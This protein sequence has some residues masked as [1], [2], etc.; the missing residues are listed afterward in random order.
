M[1]LLRSEA[2]ERG[3][4]LVTFFIAQYLMSLA[5]RRRYLLDGLPR[6]VTP[7]RSTGMQIPKIATKSPRGSLKL[8]Q[9][10]K[11]DHACVS[12][13]GIRKGLHAE[14]RDGPVLSQRLQL[15]LCNW[16]AKITLSCIAATLA[17]FSST[18]LRADA[19]EEKPCPPSDHQVL[20]ELHTIY[21]VEME[22]T[23]VERSGEPCTEYLTGR[24]KWLTD[25]HGLTLL[26]DDR[27]PIRIEA[28]DLHYLQMKPTI[29]R[30]ML[31][32]TLSRFTKLEHLDLY[33]NPLSGPIPAAVWSQTGLERLDISHATLSG[34]IPAAVGGLTE[35]RVLDLRRN[36]LTGEIPAALGN[37]ANL[38]WIN[39]RLNQLSGE[40]PAA[41]WNHPT[42][43]GLDLSFNA[44]LSGAIPLS[45]MNRP[46]LLRLNIS[47]T[48]ICMPYDDA[49]LERYDPHCGRSDGSSPCRDDY[50]RYCFAV[51]ERAAL[52][53]FFNR[54][55]G[56]EWHR[57]DGWLE[58]SWVDSWSGVKTGSDEY[59]L[60]GWRHRPKAIQK[61][62]VKRLSLSGNNLSGLIPDSLINLP[63]L[64]YL[65]FRGNQ[66]SGPIP[67][68]LGNLTNL[69][70]LR[71]ASNQLSGP[72][73]ASLANLTNLTDLFLGGNQLSGPIPASLANLT[74]LE[75]LSLAS[76]QLSG[77]I[78]ASLGNLNNLKGLGLSHNQLSGEI[79]GEL[80]ALANLEGL[81][82]SNN[83]LSGDI[84]FELEALGNLGRLD[85]SGN[86]L[87]RSI[88]RALGK[89]A[90]LKYLV[91]SNNQFGGAIPTELGNLTQL[92][93][94]RASN[95]QLGGTIPAKL[96]NLAELRR[97]NLEDNRLS[98][99]VPPALGNATEL[100]WLNL[101]GNRL[102]GPVPDALGS[103]TKLAELNLSGNRQLSGPLPLTLT[104]L[105]NL[106]ALDIRGTDLCVPR[107]TAFL[108]WLESISFDGAMC[109]GILLA[110]SPAWVSESDGPRE[111]SV[112]ATLVDGPRDL[113]TI[114]TVAV[115]EDIA[116]EGGDFQ[117][118]QAFDLTI[119][120][121]SSSASETLLFTPIDD[122]H[123]EG[124]E[125]L[126]VRG[127]ATLGGEQH[128]ATATLTL[129]D[130]DVPSTRIL[131]AVS[132]A[133]IL[134]SL[135]PTEVRVTASLAESPRN[136]STVVRVTVTGEAAL[137]AVD[138]EPVAAFD[139]IIPAGYTSVSKLLTVHP[140]DDDLEED[141]ETLL[142]RG[143]ATLEGETREAHATITLVDDDKPSTQV[144]LTLDE[145]VVSESVPLTNVT[146][147]AR[148]DSKPRTEDTAVTITVEGSGVEAAVDFNPAPSFEIT[149]LAGDASGTGLFGVR[150]EN[151]AVDERNE[152]LTVSG[153]TIVPT[154]HVV[155]TELI[156]KD[157]D[158]GKYDG[159]FIR[160][161]AGNT[162]VAD[163]TPAVDASL[164]QPSDVAVAADGT[165][166]VADRGNDR[167]RKIDP[168]GIIT[169]LAGTGDW[170]F[171]GDGG[172][173]S[174]AGLS[175]PEGLA[176]DS[177]G[178]V[179]VADAWNGRVR[180]IDITGTI[181]TLAGT[182]KYSEGGDGGPAIQ[183][184][185]GYPA[186]VAVDASG[187]VFVADSGR[188]QVSK[189]DASGTITTLAGN[190][191]WGYGGDGGP[192]IHAQFNGLSSVAVDIVGNVYVA[193]T[194]NH[195]V[196]KIDASG[197]ISTLAGNGESGDAG[198]GGPAVQAQLNRPRSVAADTV[199]N[200]FVTDA[201]NRRVR[202][203]DTAGVLTTVAGTGDWGY[204]GDGRP[205]LE[206]TLSE[207]SGVAID[208]FGNLF[209]AD[210]W[211]NRIRKID[212]LGTISTIAG[213]GDWKDSEDVLDASSV[214]FRY[215]RGAALDVSGNLL[216]SDDDRVWKL[217]PA[218]TL[219]VFAGMRN[220]SSYEE[221]GAAIDSRLLWP[222][223]IATDGFGNVYVIDRGDN[224]VRK[225]DSSGIITTLAGTGEWGFG[226]DGDLAV[227]ALLNGASSV[228][229][230]T[231]GNVYIADEFNHRVRKVDPDGVITTL[232]GTGEPGNGGDGGFATESQLRY[233]KSVAVDGASGNIYVGRYG[234]VRR[235]DPNGIITTIAETRGPV[236]A[237]AVDISGEIYVGS[238]Y[239]ISKI[240]G[241]D[242][243]VEII[244]GT[245][246]RGFRGDGGP[247]DAASLSV[248]GIAVD[249]G[250]NVWFTDGYSRRVRVLERESAGQ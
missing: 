85:L 138:F 2:S 11:V 136:A 71:L 38:A 124:D 74:N 72:I 17:I 93:E 95:G 216:F 129:V 52:V 70:G 86:R 176:V 40:V 90:N 137:E 182:G 5:G 146:V 18:D 63:E 163:G 105:T 81:N 44:Q 223:G 83:Q 3:P 204:G 102:S 148:L 169:T 116:L 236:L 28:L 31:R 201:G 186:G 69:E 217:D 245:G 77:E 150:P 215:P 224:R 47:G 222:S 9:S 152:T 100:I 117:G 158:A 50:R 156:L 220:G 131:L 46:T 133:S 244:A 242:G 91:L 35:L 241:D 160:T 178:N 76:N 155:G 135:G 227:N 33:H 59:P 229:V 238:A 111:I 32:N 173:A 141:D 195:R 118:A 243:S 97:L 221:G 139:F 212:A 49:F 61:F 101:S 21:G 202:K 167:V 25:V 1:F 228:A 187:S 109:S 37:S 7:P 89:L 120:A 126:E 106:Y 80:G 56:P 175:S 12:R 53:T 99:P 185:L 199:G 34:E 232:A 149:I 249:S 171:R 75:G 122:D 247:A 147:T 225:I 92:Q 62:T 177:A 104:K 196:R 73:P 54:T 207:I 121:G 208:S 30:D 153:T 15:G 78:P 108:E 127:T 172:P 170:G 19:G 194:G 226:G 143:S 115:A 84:P 183:A 209:F 162:D 123:E 200:V 41:L 98:G 10:R 68:W 87:S 24:A 58:D 96:G 230:D 134:E 128:E 55:G 36:G 210:K 214:T 190:G 193:D 191:D 184:W 181:S 154:L 119:P 234:G 66:L 198:D 188:S 161:V 145:S 203:I 112:T 235:I 151:D 6:Q 43:Y 42:L 107:D 218:G 144:L 29:L 113:T 159:Y 213:T 164:N 132:P 237:L 51:R 26:D 64:S 4:F 246:D 174:D 205:A 23:T 239:Q 16:R 157:D 248:S 22:H 206:A 240:Y 231:L 110:V 82:L 13:E 88:P 114:V 197:T 125:R 142:F 94:L 103:L 20:A 168:A 211:N 45:I 79:P 60:E 27:N 233:P 192:A 14:L 8:S 219:T 39:L 179:F 165:V 189:I 140:I 65:D 250:G 48:K 180:K 130:D 57:K 67:A 166:Y